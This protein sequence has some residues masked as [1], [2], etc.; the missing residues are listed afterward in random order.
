[1]P[2]SLADPTTRAA[3]MGRHPAGRAT[4][5]LGARSAFAALAEVLT[6][7]WR[8]RDP[9]GFAAT[10]T[11]G[12]VVAGHRVVDLATPPAASAGDDLQLVLRAL[13]ERGDLVVHWVAGTAQA[14]LYVEARAESPAGPSGPEV[15]VLAH[16]VEHL[17]PNGRRR[18]APA[19]HSWIFVVIGDGTGGV[20][21]V[22]R[23]SLSCPGPPRC[24][25]APAAELRFPLVRLRERLLAPALAEQGRVGDAAPAAVIPLPGFGPEGA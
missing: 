13:P 20:A 11:A 1:M 14:H 19:D 12:P 2:P 7:P 9:E 17:G 21:G 25:P 3:A 16:L 15:L 6:G 23:A 5:P 4:V 18:P 10:I 22:L 24:C 8:V